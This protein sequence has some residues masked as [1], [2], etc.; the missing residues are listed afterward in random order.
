MIRYYIILAL[1]AC[2][3]QSNGQSV[4]PSSVRG[5]VYIS[6]SE[7]AVFATVSI[8]H[9]ATDELA[10]AEATDADGIFELRG[11][12]AGSYYLLAS[13]VG[14]ED[15]RSESFDLTA[16]QDLDFGTIQLMVIAEQLD[17]VIVRAKRPMV[18]IKPDKTVFNVAGSINAQG[19]NALELLRKAPGVILDNNEN[20]MLLGKTGVIVYIDG[21]P[22]PLRNTDLANYLK[23]LSASS[24]DNIEVITNPSSKYEAEGNAGIINIR[25]KKN[26][27]IGSNFTLTGGLAAAEH[28]TY[29]GGIQFNNRG[30]NT[31]VFASYNL[32]HTENEQFLLLDR[33]IG[34]SLFDQDAT[35]FEENTGHNIKAGVDFF[36]NDNH[37]L[38][39]LMNSFIMDGTNTNNSLSEIFFEEASGF[40]DQYLDAQ[41]IIQNERDNYNVNLNYVFDN[42]DG[43]TTNIDL[44]YG[45]FKNTNI[46]DQPNAYLD[47]QTRALLQNVDY[48]TDAETDINIYT[49]KIDREQPVL[50]GTL[51][52]GVKFALVE[53]DNNYEFYN[54]G[55]Q[56]VKTLDHDRSNRFLYDENV[57]AAYFNFQRG[58]DTWNYQLGL[59]VEHTNSVGELL[60]MNGGEDQRNENDYVDFFPSG[61]I[62]YTMNQ[63]NSFRLTYSRRLN[64]PNY[65]DL[66]PFEFKLDELAFQ[67]GNPF[68]SPE[69]THNIQ[70]GHTYNYTLNTTLSY[71]RTNDLIT[72][73]TDTE[74][75]KQSFLTWENLASQD[76]Y[77]LS[78]SYPFSPR[79]WWN[80]FFNISGN[81]INNQ[82][83]SGGRFSDDKRVD[84]DAT[85]VS[86]F[87]QNTF[88][89]PKGFTFEVS[90]FYN[91]PG[92]WGGNF[93]TDEYWNVDAGFQKKFVDDKLTIRVGVSDIFKGQEWHAT[94]SFG[95]LSIDGRGG[96]ESRRFKVNLTYNF[97]NDKIKSRRRSTGLEDEKRRTSSSGGGI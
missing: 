93:E 90:G 47:G 7:R 59:R 81:Y 64:R 56:G 35:I 9:Q 52:F 6:A 53:T 62:T 23:G 80:A 50:K 29:D 95:D 91:S 88:E 72:R 77:S 3:F 27:N 54:V 82:S 17:E 34:P 96:Y 79:P 71:S 68:L 84:V 58:N 21:K 94:N 24:I 28:V 20:I 15:Y 78:V 67:K 36:I 11:L 61:G 10:K 25:L 89:L 22:S 32:N 45:I 74:D 14:Y 39:V 33:R 65:Q 70:V 18:E 48:A 44:D 63:K 2:I 8:H 51:G 73:L 76:A 43:T 86:I 66:N 60:A 41:N 55:E 49:I 57:N 85:F 75:G 26:E 16:G 46:S 92:I 42:K 13:Y 69:Y 12:A 19:G 87:G 30:K 40:R 31:N 4:A 1:L 97:G 5:D 83:K 37:T 38:G